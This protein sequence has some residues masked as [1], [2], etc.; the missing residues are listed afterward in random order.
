MVS[1]HQLLV[2]ASNLSV[3]LGATNIGYGRPL[4]LLTVVCAVFSCAIASKITRQTAELRK[5]ADRQAAFEESQDAKLDAIL[6]ML[7]KR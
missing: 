5:I 1:S 3:S 6:S 4:G 7:Q 2:V